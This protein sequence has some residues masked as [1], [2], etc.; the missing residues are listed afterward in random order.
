MEP[1]LSFLSSLHGIH[2]TILATLEFLFSFLWFNFFVHHFDTYYLAADKGVRR[3]H[4]VLRR[5][6]DV[7]VHTSNLICC[8][9]RALCILFVAH[10]CNA[11]T[12]LEFQY[13]AVFV[14]IASL[15]SAHRH[16]AYQRPPQLFVSMW[17][18]ELAASMI[19]G[20]T[21]FYLKEY[22]TLRS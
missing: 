22:A 8:A 3:A 7:V 20:V 21:A 16:F 2:V 14:T 19:V 15:L 5:Y 10:L 11:C 12:L 1:F 6:P 13:A 4:H 18:F 17:G 9:L